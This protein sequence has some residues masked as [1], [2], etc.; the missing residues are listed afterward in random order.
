VTRETGFREGHHGTGPGAFTPDGCAVDLYLRVPAG[1][2]PDVVE[3]A[4]PAGA[5]ILEPT[6]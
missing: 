3:A 1:P 4:V 2:E 6:W 5:T